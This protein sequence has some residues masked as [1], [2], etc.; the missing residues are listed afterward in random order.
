VQFEALLDRSIEE[1]RRAQIC[2][3]IVAAAVFNANPFRGKHAK[4]V[5]PLEFVAEDPRKREGEMDVE[6][7]GLA[8]IA[9]W[10]SIAGNNLKHEPN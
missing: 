3:G 6:A 4:A 9:A 8:F 1:Q 7:Q 5:K 2:A 10:S